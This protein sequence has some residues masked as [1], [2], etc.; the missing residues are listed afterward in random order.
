MVYIGNNRWQY[1]DD[2]KRQHVDEEEKAN[3]NGVDDLNYLRW[4]EQIVVVGC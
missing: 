1:L 2:G 3:D 4:V